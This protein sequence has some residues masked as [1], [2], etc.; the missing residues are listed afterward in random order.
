M[1]YQI[2]FMIKKKRA[3]VSSLSFYILGVGTVMLILT[4]DWNTLLE[5]WFRLVIASLFFIVG[6]VAHSM[7]K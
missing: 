2:I 4:S 3:Q 5:G 6:A 7:N 1:F